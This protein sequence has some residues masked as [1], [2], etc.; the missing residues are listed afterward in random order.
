MEEFRY[1][2]K[3]FFS[4]NLEVKKKS[5]EILNKFFSQQKPYQFCTEVLEQSKNDNDD[6]TCFMASNLIRK[7]VIR[8]WTILDDELKTQLC[9]FI[10]K[11]TMKSTKNET[12]NQLLSCYSMIQKRSWS[13]NE[14]LKKEFFQILQSLLTSNENKLFVMKLLFS[15]ISEFSNTNCSLIGMTWEDH[16]KSSKIFQTELLSQMYQYSMTFLSTFLKE[17]PKNEIELKMCEISLNI[18]QSFLNW[19]F[20]TTIFIKDGYDK[21]KDD[22]I[23][24]ATS[25]KK[26]I[27]MLS[28]INTLNLLIQLNKKFITYPT[29]TDLIRKSLYILSSLPIQYIDSTQNQ[30]IYL[31]TFMNGIFHLYSNS[32]EV[33]R[34]SFDMEI[35]D[36]S[37]IMLRLITNYHIDAFSKL[38]NFK[39]ILETFLSLSV[40]L[41][42]ISVKESIGESLTIILDTWVALMPQLEDNY[43][44]EVMKFLEDCCFTLFQ[45]YLSINDY[46]EDLMN[47]QLECVGYLGR[48]CSYQSLSLLNQLL[49]EKLKVLSNI[50]SNVSL[51]ST[52][53][54]LE[55]IFN[56]CGYLL[57]D[58][59]TSEVPLIPEHFILLTIKDKTVNNPLIVLFN[60]ILQYS[61]FESNLLK[62]K[63]SSVL[64][65]LISEKLIWF[66]RRFSRSYL[67]P[68]EDEYSNFSELL[69]SNFSKNGNG[70]KLAEYFFTKIQI[71]LYFWQHEPDLM[72]QT[73]E[74]F[75]TL[76]SNNSVISHLANLK[77]WDDF[78][79][80]DSKTFG[81]LN[82][83]NYVKG[84]ITECLT[85]GSFYFV[86]IDSYQKIQEN[87]SSKVLI[88]L[89]KQFE[90]ILQNQNFQKNYQ[91]PEVL[92]QLS[93]C[94]EKYRGIARAT[95]ISN[96]T[97]I[98]EFFEKT[99]LFENLVQLSHSYH[100][101]NQI[102]FQIFEFF[103][104]CAEFQMF[105][106]NMEQSYYLYNGCIGVMKSFL[107][108]NKGRITSIKYKEDAED[109][110]YE[111]LLIQ[112]NILISLIQKDFFYSG[113][114]E[115]DKNLPM[116][117]LGGV[118]I[119][120][121][122]ITF[123]L[124]QFPKLCSQYFIL[125]NSMFESYSEE[126][127]SL[128]ID[129]FKQIMQSL[130]FGV[131]HH[132]KEIV[133][134]SFDT[135][136]NIL[137]FQI[138]SKEGF[139]N[140]LFF[141]ELCA[142]FLKTII[143][144]SFYERIPNE[145][146]ENV[147]F[148]LF[149]LIVY[150][151]SQYH[152]VIKSIIDEMNETQIKER[153]VLGFQILEEN[154]NLKWDM[155]C[156]AQFTKNFRKFLS[157]VRAFMIKQ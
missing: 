20:S 33:K 90:S 148:C 97:L 83:T 54:D 133:K 91:K 56:F 28:D 88:P 100:N 40:S 128:S 152:N 139:T 135:I 52:W 111:D 123:D 62:S 48:Y 93:Y 110:S 32:F 109:E 84:C 150:D 146:I 21:E 14:K 155:S 13:E 126:L 3:N 27:K 144:I 16:K 24:Y 8:E 67:I 61:D 156:K 18:L 53:D 157:F 9:S 4:T 129:L 10:L 132:D 49:V 125:I 77:E 71:N 58:D 81:T 68:K 26:W 1:G 80:E 122:L 136:Y 116:V 145:A 38:E 50:S 64:S 92:N 82:H 115:F 138:S 103:K 46:D 2:C 6:Y 66:F 74:F 86:E 69:L 106:L 102:L 57:C 51:D 11:Y 85:K 124:L 121:P 117:I 59:P 15:M 119:L 70:K 87:Y 36:C 114:D 34:D 137:D 105:H 5:E 153:L 78:L 149:G 73:V 113:H 107:K 147:S 60:N 30:L 37:K 35:Y 120:L 89:T 25:D 112:I 108:Y 154:M 96:A 95:E 44:Q 29:I 130:D 151:S 55:T 101:Q 99:K 12:I 118:E 76:V 43:N 22:T 131:K 19:D 31:S 45:S 23:I 98:C 39:Q 63:N 140:Q 127:K 104:D 94:I 7:S 65:S 141:K 79:I 17:D 47:E 142:H 72:N 41:M 143:F 134:Y 75:R 42:K